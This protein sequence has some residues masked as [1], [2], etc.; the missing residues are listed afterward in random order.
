M[1]KKFKSTKKSRRDFLRQGIAAV[2]GVATL[3]VVGQV[4]AAEAPETKAVEAT[5]APQAKGYQETAHIREYY[6][7]ARF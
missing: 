5:P 1:T 7:L 2:G 4:S 3:A 6:G